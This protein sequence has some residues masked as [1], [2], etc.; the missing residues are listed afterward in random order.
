MKTHR[1]VPFVRIQLERNRSHTGRRTATPARHAAAYF[2]FGHN[3]T[4]Q[5]GTWVDAEGKTHAHTDVLAWARKGA[6]RHDYTFQAL[7]SV[8]QGRLDSAG[9]TEALQQAGQIE[10]WRLVVHDDTAHSHAHVLFFRNKRLPKAEHK[11]WHDTLQ[12]Q[13]A[14]LES[15]QLAGLASQV[16]ELTHDADRQRGLGVV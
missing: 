5:R 4:Q 6:L 14:L 3:Q 16:G 11:A 9:Y 2:A 7:L 1:S 15:K 13:L 10:D 12:A 8:P